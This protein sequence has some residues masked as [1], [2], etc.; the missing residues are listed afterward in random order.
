VLTDDAFAK[1]VGLATRFKARVDEIIGSR[2]LQWH[3]AQLGARAEY[4]FCA[5]PPRTGGES[6][7]AADK[8]LDEYLHCYLL[9]REVLIT[10]FHNMVLMSPATREADVDGLA[11]TLASAVDELL[12]TP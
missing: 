3:V 5:A 4:R 10:P 2:Q 12:K 7:A 9:N 11:S 8:E 6:A 1:M